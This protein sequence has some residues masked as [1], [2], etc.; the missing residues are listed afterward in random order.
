MRIA[1]RTR[2]VMCKNLKFGTVEWTFLGCM[3]CWWRNCAVDRT[4]SRHPIWIGLS[5]KFGVKWI[6]TAPHT[7]TYIYMQP[8]C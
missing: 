7:D 1:R 6:D 8:V 4:G 5:G 3:V 2:R